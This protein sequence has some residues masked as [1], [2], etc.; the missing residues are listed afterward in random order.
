MLSVVIVDR[1]EP[2]S[3]PPVHSVDNASPDWINCQ[4]RR[5][6]FAPA[7]LSSHTI[8]LIRSRAT[9]GCWSQ[10]RRCFRDRARHDNLKGPLMNSPRPHRVGAG[11]AVATLREQIAVRRAI[12]DQ[13]ISLV[14]LL[15]RPVRTG[16]RCT[17]R[18]RQRR[19][20]AVGR[21]RRTSAGRRVS[22]P[23]GQR[24]GACRNGR[25]GLEAERDTSANRAADG[26]GSNPATRRRGAGP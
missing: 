20:R 25:C 11:R 13:V 3:H 2:C 12:A 6:T 7:T 4:V 5:H 26:V 24:V 17:R 21:W 15:G 9:I 10:C 23:C 1:V 14:Q 18:A 8:V 22:N 16:R 19:C